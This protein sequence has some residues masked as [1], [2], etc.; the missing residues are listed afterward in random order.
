MP[1]HIKS[2]ITEDKKVEPIS[3][4]QQQQPQQ[5]QPMSVQELQ[6]QLMVANQQMSIYQEIE[7]LSKEEIFRYNLLLAMQKNNQIQAEQNENLKLIG[8]ILINIGKVI[9]GTTEEEK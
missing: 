5:Q 7:S 8:K 9:E 2:Q 1:V 6:E 4:E 3:Q